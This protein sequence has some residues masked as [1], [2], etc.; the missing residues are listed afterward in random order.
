MLLKDRFLKI[1][2]Y[3]TNNEERFKK[4][5]IQLNRVVKLICLLQPLPNRSIQTTIC[6]RFSSLF[7]R[8]SQKAIVTNCNIKVSNSLSYNSSMNIWRFNKHNN[9]SKNRIVAFY[10]RLLL[11]LLLGLG[12][13]YY[14]WNTSNGRVSEVEIIYRSNE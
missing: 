14:Q 13:D 6:D 9:S 2:F 7:F 1:P 12:Q 8:F 4:R 5:T 11:L 3:E 10:Y